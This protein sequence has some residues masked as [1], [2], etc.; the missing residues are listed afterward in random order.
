MAGQSFDVGIGFEDKG[1]WLFSLAE[2]VN[3]VEGFGS[4]SA[5]KKGILIEE[6]LRA[7]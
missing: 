1:L 7:L 6:T 2:K 3:G 5:G 4:P